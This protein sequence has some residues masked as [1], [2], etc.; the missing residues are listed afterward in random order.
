MSLNAP[1]RVSDL[2]HRALEHS[3]D[4][5]E[6]FLKTACGDDHS[7]FSEVRDLLAIYREVETGPTPGETDQLLGARLGAYEIVRLIGCGGMGRVYLGRRADG[8]FNLDV[9]IKVIES[10]NQT[11][12]LVTRFEQERRI[13]GSLRHPCIAQLFDAG[14]S[15][16]GHLYFVMEYVDGVPLTEFCH[17]GALSLRARLELFC[18][19]CDAV[20]AAHRNLVV[21]RDLK[22]GNILVDANGTPKLLDFGIAKPLTRSG[23][24]ASDPT[25]PILRRATPAY[26]S[27]EQL[28][29]DAAHTGMDVF[30][31][32]VVLY[33]LVTGHRPHRASQDQTTTMTGG[34]FVAPSVALAHDGA[35][36]G[37]GITPR[38]V[39]GDLDA[40]ILKSLYP[41]VSRRYGSVDTLVKDLRAHLAGYPVTA[42]PV[43][44]LNRLWRVVRR[45]PALSV[46]SGVAV[47]AAL[48]ATISVTRLALVATRERD[49]AIEQV[50]ELK[51]L[52]SSTFSLDESLSRVPGATA[53]RRQLVE[54]LNAYLSRVRVGNDRS[55]AL[56]TA[57]GYRRLGDIKG[58]PNGS[59]LGD[60][61]GALESYQTAKGL[62]TPLQ[63]G[64]QSED[65]TIALVGIE[66]S[67]GDI[68]M[69]QRTLGPADEAYRNAL[70]LAE[71]LVVPGSNQ[72][73]HRVL[74]ARIHRPYGDLKQAAGDSAAALGHYE[75]ALAIDL[76]NTQ[77]FPA[78]PEYR[79]TLALSY[80]RIAAIRASQGV[81][82]EA[83]ASYE[84]ATKIL[85]ELASAG[86]VNV[87]LRREVAFGRARLGLMLE[88]EGN[89]AGRIE[90][91]AA[92]DDFRA[93][94]SGDP[95]DARPRRDLMATLVQ[96]GD[97][98]RIDDPTAARAA[99][100]EAR[101]I[102]MTLS[103][104][105]DADNPAAGDLVLVDHRLAALAARRN[106]TELK[107]FKVIDGRR[108]LLQ[109]GDPPPA[110]RTQ[111]AAAALASPG[112]SRYLLVF[113]ADGPAEI[114]ED[115]DLS[116]SGWV[117]AA[118]GPPP[119][120]T[121]LLVATPRALP[122]ED[123]RRLREA[124][125]AV[126]GPRTVD[127]ESQIVWESTSPTIESTITAR[128]GESSLWVAAVLHRIRTLGEVAIAGRTFPLAPETQ[129]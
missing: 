108:V 15:D 3:P 52:A 68:L 64:S 31:L 82:T 84:Q 16:S 95:A 25:R 45:N 83:R 72:A 98:I 54:A 1:N 125:T 44:P 89:A 86:N 7:L 94:A 35:S 97:A 63:K 90:I 13:L 112:W 27:P 77:Q 93:L 62:L 32:G 121:I 70:T 17:R 111:I 74:R 123:K 110:V 24:E 11:E 26:A 127:W 55:L 118:P 76:A 37:G 73:A 20:D 96:L 80:F 36:N 51:S 67:I 21:H 115:R 107:L 117:I 6:S 119:A 14:R 109:T 120:Q 101:E 23:L 103:A 129:D 61:S 105:Q 126:E 91:L 4:S 66:A 85:K 102:A 69:A 99:Y 48:A 75:K 113:G 87:G 40:I 81:P 30:S 92:V 65:V 106:L 50:R 53:P 79:R 33:E 57:E 34:G 12:E 38:E 88:A 124:L 56:E 46:A 41:D 47:I 100:R 9:A 104:D 49:A 71:S 116:R 2:F 39:H 43:A 22:P 114:F 18:R 42:R 60:L 19:V 29:G 5:R 128:S 10:S 59:N 78:D 58:N 8:A 28:R 122:D